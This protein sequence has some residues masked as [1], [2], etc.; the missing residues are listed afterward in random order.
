[1]SSDLLRIKAQNYF[2]LCWLSLLPPICLS[3]HW[4]SSPSCTNTGE[5]K[6][7]TQQ[8][9]PN[10]HMWHYTSTG[11]SHKVRRLEGLLQSIKVNFFRW[12]KNR[13]LREESSLPKPSECLLVKSQS[14]TLCSQQKHWHH[15]CFFFFKSSPE[16]MKA[17]LDL[18]IEATEEMDFKIG[19]RFR[20]PWG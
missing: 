7:G 9:L 17:A 10:M 11:K 18:P 19:R 1:M 3:S 20:H 16:L 14:N 6:I 12:S 15:Y 13:R 5:W 2:V 4:F 8:Q